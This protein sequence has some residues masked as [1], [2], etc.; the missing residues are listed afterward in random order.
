MK[1]LQIKH[2]KV[3]Y[4]AIFSLVLLPVLIAYIWITLS[5]WLQYTEIFW[6]ILTIIF[7]TFIGL[8]LGLIVNPILTYQR[9]ADVCVSG[10]PIP[11]SYGVRGE[12]G[13]ESIRFQRL[14]YIFDI[15][16]YCVFF[17]AAGILVYTTGSKY[18][19]FD[20]ELL[21]ILFSVVIKVFL[22]DVLKIDSLSSMRW[23]P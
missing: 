14:K 15:A 11:V 8:G 5:E 17:V 18:S 7:S 22:Y 12:Y 6:L 4:V 20:S 3:T 13:C 10:I 19:I 9:D 16:Y 1:C 21:V 23:D 2:D